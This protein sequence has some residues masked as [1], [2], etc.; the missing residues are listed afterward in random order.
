MQPLLIPNK[1]ENGGWMIERAPTVSTRRRSAQR[2]IVKAEEGG[3]HAVRLESSYDASA[4][5]KPTC[6]TLPT[7]GRYTKEQVG[8]HEPHG[9][10]DRPPECGREVIAHFPPNLH[11]LHELRSW[12]GEGWRQELARWE[13]EEPLVVVSTALGGRSPTSVLR[14]GERPV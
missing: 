4:V 9:L 6:S 8:L 11:S 13:I 2:T 10:G 14:D 3:F 7:A 1:E 5:G 12:L